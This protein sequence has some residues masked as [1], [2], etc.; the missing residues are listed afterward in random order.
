MDINKKISLLN[1]RQKYELCRQIKTLGYELKQ[2]AAGAYINMK[3]I[4]KKHLEYI[5]RYI[6]KQF[7]I[8]NDS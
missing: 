2:T 7:N 8:A 6:D 5:Y 1:L 4:E 3:E